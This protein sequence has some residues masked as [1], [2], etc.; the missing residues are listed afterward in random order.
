MTERAAAPQPRIH[1]HRANNQ[2]SNTHRSL[3]PSLSSKPLISLQVLDEMLTSSP[4]AK[5]GNRCLEEGPG[6]VQSRL[7][8]RLQRGQQQLL[9]RVSSALMTLACLDSASCQKR[10]PSAG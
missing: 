3:C 8:S 5:R 2:N 4:S 6:A 9:A 1:R 10:T 7:R